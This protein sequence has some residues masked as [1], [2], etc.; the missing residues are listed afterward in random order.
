MAVKALYSLDISQ[1]EML[2]ERGYGK[3]KLYQVIK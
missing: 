2:W 3:I 1:I